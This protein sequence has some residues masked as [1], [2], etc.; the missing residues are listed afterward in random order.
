MRLAQSLLAGIQSPS[1]S[2]LPH[3]R[4]PPSF[5]GLH[6]T[7]LVLRSNLVST[8]V[9]LAVLCPCLARGGIINMGAGGWLTKVYSRKVK[10]L[11]VACK[12]HALGSVRDPG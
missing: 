11:Q 3:S 5:R 7:V 4:A 1:Q 2:L 9:I 10:E 8:E 12:V 6:S